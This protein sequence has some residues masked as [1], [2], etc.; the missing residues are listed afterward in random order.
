MVEWQ[1]GRNEGRRRPAHKIFRKSLETMGFLHL[2]IV[3]KSGGLIHHRPLSSKAPKI[4]TNEWLRIGSTFHSLHAIAA[5]ASPVKLENDGIEQIIAGGLVLRC[6]QSKT[7]LKFVVT[8]EPNT[9]DM[10]TALKGI[11]G[12]YA[13]SCLKDPFYEVDM[14]IK[15]EIFTLG[16]DEL[17][18]RLNNTTTSRSSI[19]HSSIK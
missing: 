11:Y 16:V 3:N 12:I 6:F 13:D 17:M 19:R 9:P 14:P 10:D 7:G 1:N 4:G 8:A 15:S 2:F 5:E 18:E